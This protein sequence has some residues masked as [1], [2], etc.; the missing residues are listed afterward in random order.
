MPVNQCSP[1]A[2]ISIYIILG[3]TIIFPVVSRLLIE[4]GRKKIEEKNNVI[5]LEIGNIYLSNP[6]V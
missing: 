3:K 1:F 5:L 4:L 6:N 2:I